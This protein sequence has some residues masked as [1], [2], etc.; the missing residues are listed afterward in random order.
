MSEQTIPSE[1]RN[2]SIDVIEEKESKEQSHDSPRWNWSIKL[3][4]AIALL[5]GALALAIRFNNYL[6][7]FLTALL[8]SFL[9]QP[10]VRWV[11]KHTK[12][13]WRLVSGIVYLILLALII[14]G[15]ASGSKGLAGQVT[16]LF[17]SLQENISTVTDYIAS[18]SNKKI[19]LG[20]LNFNLPKLDM[21]FLTKKVEEFLQ[22]LI[23]SVTK[24]VPKL[25]GQVGGFVFNSFITILV[26]FFITSESGTAKRQFVALK[27]HAYDDDIKRMGREVAGNFNAYLRGTMIVV[28]IGIVIYSALLGALGVPYFFLLAVIAGFGR[29]IP[30]LG[31]GIGWVGFFVGTLMQRPT[32]FGMAPLGYAVLVLGIALVID[33]I[34]DNVVTPTVM[35][36]ALDVHP[37]AILISALVGAQLFG[38]LGVIL[39]APIYAILKLLLRYLIHKLFDEDPWEGI[40]YYQ[41]P[42]EVGLVKGLRKLCERF[43]AWTEKPRQAF[44]AWVKKVWEKIVAFFKGWFAKLPKREKKRKRKEK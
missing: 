41:K 33:F 35:S 6:K 18:W 15:V 34:L 20:P 24:N 19:S 3:V 16:S 43:W 21:P 9:I 7:L 29:F 10:I 5:G 39:A 8:I 38:L 37:A 32:P 12:L 42:K 36:N 25:V 31:A 30:Y 23:T 11:T 1:K 4:V 14:W 27:N 44:V 13:N 28:I 17:N 22:P 26:S 2:T 40:E